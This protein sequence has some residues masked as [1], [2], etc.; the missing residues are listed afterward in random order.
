MTALRAF[1]IDDE[2]LALRRLR[3][4]LEAAGGVEVV[5]QSTDP[6]E[7]LADVGKQAVDV[8]F[9]DIHMPELSGFELVE[10]L[11]PG[12]RV[13]FTTAYDHHAV[14]AFEVHAVDYLLKPIE[15]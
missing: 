13:V 9:L 10:R 4:L 3:R 11:P 6:V 2:P 7:G 12:P 15:R 14:Q 1:L 8:L 5:G